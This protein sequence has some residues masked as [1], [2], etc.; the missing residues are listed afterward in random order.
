M[1]ALHAICVG[2]NVASTN[3]ATLRFA[4]RDAQQFRD[5]LNS[6]QL[7]AD[8]AETSLV[9]SYSA[10]ELRASISSVTAEVSESDS[11]L[12]YYA[13][14]GMRELDPVDGSEQ[15]WLCCGLKTGKQPSGSAV[16]LAE[17]F[18][19]LARSSAASVVVIL[20]CCFS[21]AQGGRSVLGPDVLR[22]LATGRPLLRAAAPPL[23]GHG[24]VALTA[25]K[26]DQPAYE[27]ALHRHGVFTHAL[28]ER[29]SRGRGKG[30]DL[31]TVLV[32]VRTAV[33]RSTKGQQCPSWFG[34]DEGME[35]PT[36]V[37][38]RK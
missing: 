31:A 24:R 37:D 3:G 2:S 36:L 26:H 6:Q 18:D 9:G 7:Y 19:S 17:I 21:G 11:V 5:R 32:D 20:D 15:L 30:V 34:G 35:L 28:L 23:P 14:H 8:L 4:E 38:R 16:P 10:A 1:S 13:G 22:L 12:F 33:L 29:L 25:S 27:S